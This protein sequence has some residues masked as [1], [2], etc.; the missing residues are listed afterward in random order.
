MRRLL[1]LALAL[2]IA[3]PAAARVM[4][5]ETRA[6]PTLDGTEQVH[7]TSDGRF[8]IRYTLEGGDALEG[9]AEDESPANGLPDAVDGVVVGLVACWDLYVD[10]EGWR[11][12]ADDGTEGGDARLDVYLRHIDHNG[13]AHQ[14]WHGDHWAAYLEI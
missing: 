3:A 1:V 5:D 11:A 7:D 8:R 9:M 4:R 14:E 12:P 6:R 13:L 2:L 10:G